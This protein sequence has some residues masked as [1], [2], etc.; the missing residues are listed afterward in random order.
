MVEQYWVRIVWSSGWGKF[1][2]ELLLVTDV[3]TTWS[4]VIF[5]VKWIV[6]VSRWCYKV[7]PYQLYNIIDWVETIYYVKRVCYL[8]IFVIW[9]KEIIPSV[10][11]DALLFCFF[12]PFFPV[13]E[14]CQSLHANRNKRK[15]SEDFNWNNIGMIVICVILQAR[16]ISAD[17]FLQCYV[18]RIC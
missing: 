18:I 13:R 14:P 8:L 10:I 17:D 2:K 6:I 3:S 5:R 15:R 1:W 4:E 9:E 16:M 11:R 12:P 7:G